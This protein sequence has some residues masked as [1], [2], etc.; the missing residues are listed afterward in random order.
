MQDAKNAYQWRSVRQT[1]QTEQTDTLSDFIYT[2]S[3]TV[4]PRNSGLIICKRILSVIDRF[5]LIRGVYL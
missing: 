4:V 1:E 5:P 2:D 3:Y